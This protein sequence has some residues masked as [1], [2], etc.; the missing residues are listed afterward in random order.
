M[1]NILYL[2]NYYYYYYYGGKTSEEIQGQVRKRAAYFEG[3]YCL[4]LQKRQTV[5]REIKLPRFFNLT[6]FNSKPIFPNQNT[7]V[8]K[9][10]DIYSCVM[11]LRT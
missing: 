1:A 5:S 6:N 7:L 8:S 10:S 3:E 11:Y 9:S 2:H 4:Q